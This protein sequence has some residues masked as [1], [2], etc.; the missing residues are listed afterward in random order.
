VGGKNIFL[1]LNFNFGI[2]VFLFN[3]IINF[4]LLIIIMLLKIIYI[5]K[6]QILFIFIKKKKKKKKENGGKG[7]LNDEMY[8]IRSEFNSIR[9]EI[10]ICTRKDVRCMDLRTGKIQKIFTGLVEKSEDEL[11]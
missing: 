10:V 6:I 8:P 2:L 7:S 9:D 1:F 11:T 5:L 4:F 3:L